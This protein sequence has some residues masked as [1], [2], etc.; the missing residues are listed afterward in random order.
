MPSRASEARKRLIQTALGLFASR[1]YH[2]TSIEDIVQKSGITR[3]SLFYRFPS[4]EALG[5][6][7]IEEEMRL[8][9]EQGAASHLGTDDHPIDR[10]VKALDA[11]PNITKLG[12]M[13]SSATDLAVRMASVH[14]GFRKRLGDGMLAAVE[15]VEEIVRRGVS[16]GQIA[17]SVDPF[18]VA[19]LYVTVGAGVQFAKLLWE[20]EVIWEDSKRWLQEYLNSLRA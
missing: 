5:Y 17:D 11:L 19:H 13:G 7:V 15:Q 18:V 6:A 16:D 2:N 20:R 3:G 14:E 10:L 4:K 12:E 1:G 8:L 9:Y